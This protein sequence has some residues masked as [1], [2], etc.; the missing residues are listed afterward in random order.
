MVDRGT[1]STDQNA[2]TAPRLLRVAV[3]DLVSPSYFPMIAAARMRLGEPD[4]LD[5][6]LSLRFPVTEAAQ[7][8]RRNELDVLAGAAHA[9]LFAFPG[10]RGVKLLA[11]LSRCTYWLLVVRA[12]LDIARNDVGGLRGLRIAAAPGPDVALA[13]L[14][15]DAGV[16]HG[17]E[18]DMVHVVPVPTAD[19]EPT[20]FGVAA[21]EALQAARIDG[22]WANGMGA[23]VAVRRG[24]GSVVVDARRGDGPAQLASYTFPAAMATDRTITERPG[25]LAALVRAVARAQALLREDPGLATAVAE[26]LFPP[27][28]TSLIAELIRRDAPF[29]DAAITDDAVAGL[30]A[31]AD[32]AGLLEAPV[33]RRDAVVATLPGVG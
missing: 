22:F 4:G 19:A 11:A 32:R 23:E 30:N 7:A 33:H 5:I 14:L 28:E 29:Y 12:D 15:E 1:V 10:W 8:L 9:A 25:T 21:A 2:T 31:F 17:D 16:P 24:I 18:P 3:P 13:M 26:G 27:M 6:E 20:S